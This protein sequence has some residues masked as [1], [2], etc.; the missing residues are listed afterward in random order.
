MGINLLDGLKIKATGIGSMPHKDTKYVCEFILE[1]FPDLPFWPQLSKINPR[2]NMLIQYSENLP[3]LVRDLEKKGVY[4]NPKLNREEELLKFY[5]KFTE[6]DIGYFKISPEYAAGFYSLL[7]EAGNKSGEYLKGQVVGPITFLA[8]VTDI[9]GK[10]LLYDEMLSDA[11]IKAL[12]MKAVWQIKEIE[13]IN[14]K[15]IIFF[16]EPYLS[17]FGSAFCNLSR[18][19]VVKTLN[20][21]I[22][23][24]K[25]HGN[26]PVGVHCC[27]NTDWAMMLET[28][29][30][31]LSFDFFGFGKNFTL[32]PQPIKK[33][34]A[35]GGIIAFGVVPTSEYNSSQTISLLQ[36]KFKNSLLELEKKGIDKNSLLKNSIFTPSCG[37]GLLSEETAEK[38]VKLTA[39]FAQQFSP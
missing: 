10:A 20:D 31:I 37:M 35:R 12:G 36:D 33:F 1:N 26:I 8:S 38:I 13:K 3:C 14:K 18:E 9:E 21:I 7:K 25:G 32:Y 27:G 24:V 23:V 19:Q 2:E 28:E 4:L 5:E 22:Q 6:N 34:M 17:S 16:D 30:D 29:I 11:V 15:P 39:E